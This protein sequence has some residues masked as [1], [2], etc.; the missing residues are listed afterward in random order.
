MFTP[1]RSMISDYRLFWQIHLLEERLVPGV[2]LKIPKEQVAL[3]RV[4]ILISSFVGA[5]QP[6]E[7]TTNAIPD[8]AS[9]RT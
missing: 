4:Q 9:S 7:R 6:L 1:A 5:G 8:H 3:D 2:A